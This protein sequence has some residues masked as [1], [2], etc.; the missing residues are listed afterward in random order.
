MT[1]FYFS[2]NLNKHGELRRQREAESRLFMTL[3]LSF[4]ILTVVL[5]GAVFYFYLSLGRK[6][7]NRH[8][9]LQSINREIETYRESGEYLSTDDLERL[10]RTSTDRIFW[11]N[12][13]I[14]LADITTDKIAITRFSYKDNVLSLFGITQVDREEKEFDLIHEFI[15]DLRVHEQ[16]EL[17]FDEI[18]FVRSHR[19]REKDV[20]IL[21]FQID[22]IGKDI[23]DRER[24]RRL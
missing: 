9:L 3:V 1:Q 10:A 14:A 24:R 21:R 18:R 16:I 22:C 7:D 5:Y 11:A 19:D 13:L 23:T 8:E 4:A 20:D 15:E 17:D 6:L 2:I 12:K